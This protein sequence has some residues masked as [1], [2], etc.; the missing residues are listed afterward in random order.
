MEEKLYLIFLAK[1]GTTEEAWR[2]YLAS[3]GC[4][5]HLLRSTPPGRRSLAQVVHSDPIEQSEPSFVLIHDP[6]SLGLYIR[7]PVDLAEKALVLGEL[8]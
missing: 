4:T 8:P 1:I 5:V 3:L 7:V 2:S 6:S